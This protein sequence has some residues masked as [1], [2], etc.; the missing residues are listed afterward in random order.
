M[1]VCQRT[2]ARPARP[3]RLASEARERGAGA[4][5]VLRPGGDGYPKCLI[6]DALD[7]RT[8]DGWTDGRTDGRTA[9]F[10]FVFVG[11]NGQGDVRA[12][13]L[14]KQANPDKIER[15]YIHLVQVWF[16]PHRVGERASGR[17]GERERE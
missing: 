3:A 7:G 2:P 1:H 16:S 12:A 14:M 8:T 13:E 11:D 6:P 9:Q 5:R 4:H 10:S 15:V 17:A